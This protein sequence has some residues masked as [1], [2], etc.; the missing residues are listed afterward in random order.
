MDRVSVGADLMLMVSK[1]KGVW[2]EAYPPD[3]LPRWAY[4]G[5]P[6]GYPGGG[7]GGSCWSL[8]SMKVRVDPSISGGIFC[9]R[10]Y[11]A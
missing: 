10:G 1:P 2:E 6:P 5:V 9:C 3:E 11:V 7:G 4:P 8:G